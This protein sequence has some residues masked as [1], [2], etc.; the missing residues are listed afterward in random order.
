MKIP[1]L[2]THKKFQAGI[3]ASLIIFVGMFF[4]ALAA[5][6]DVALALGMVEW[7]IVMAPTMVA[8]GA[9]GVAD[10]G[11]ERAKEELWSNKATKKVQ[12]TE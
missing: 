8:I 2:L 12:E 7:A 11:K 5:T 1:D 3:I 4:T 10:V 9:Q 6:G